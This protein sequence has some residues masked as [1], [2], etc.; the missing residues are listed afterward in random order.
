MLIYRITLPA[1]QDPKA[2]VRF[3]KADYFPAVP[4]GSTRIGQ[5]VEMV[6]LQGDTTSITHE[7]FLHVSGLMSDPR[8]QDQAVQQKLA[9]F[10]VRLERVGDFAPAAVWRAGGRLARKVEHVRRD[11]PQQTQR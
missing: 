11:D 9:S 2:F 5:V 8:V 7:F 6:L 3:M 10:G 4:K 1:D